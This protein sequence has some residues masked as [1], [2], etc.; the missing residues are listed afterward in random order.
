MAA[1]ALG[2]AP[3]CWELSCVLHGAQSGPPGTRRWPGHWTGGRARKRGSLVN[4]AT[5]P[6]RP[7]VSGQCRALRHASDSESSCLR[8]LGLARAGWAGALTRK[9]PWP[10]SRPRGRCPVRRRSQGAPYPRRTGRRRGPGVSLESRAV[11]APE[12]RVVRVDCA[13]HV[14]SPPSHADARTVRAACT[15]AVQ[16]K[17]DSRRLPCHG[18]RGHVPAAS[19]P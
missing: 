18:R 3:C 17:R 6:T 7:C 15:A 12:S 9:A 2:L 16:L 8:G 5:I 19:I 14:W 13:R 11:P 4:Q 1:P 10:E